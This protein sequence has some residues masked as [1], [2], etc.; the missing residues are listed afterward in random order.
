MSCLF[1]L[2]AFSLQLSTSYSAFICPVRRF[3]NEKHVGSNWK[4]YK[5]KEAFAAACNSKSV[6]LFGKVAWYLKGFICGNWEFLLI[7]TSN[8][9]KRSNRKLGSAVPKTINKSSADFVTCQF[10]VDAHS[11]GQFYCLDR[12][13]ILDGFKK[14][15]ALATAWPTAARGQDSPP[16]PTV[17]DALGQCNYEPGLRQCIGRG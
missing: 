7:W 8:C 6:L 10:V 9:G 12:N 16:W 1:R 2:A 11:C 15:L 5:T 17:L 3:Y 14:F 4:G 13:K